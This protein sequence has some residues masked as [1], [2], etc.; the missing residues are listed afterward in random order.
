[1]WVWVGAGLVVALLVFAYALC[2]AA[3][4]A[5]LHEMADYAALER[6][7]TSPWEEP[8][9]GGGVY[10]AVARGEFDE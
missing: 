5:D 2:R 6:R 10:D 8:R 7:A 1:M 4:M 9:V 3:A